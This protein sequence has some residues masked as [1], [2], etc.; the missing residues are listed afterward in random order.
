MRSAGLSFGN[1]SAMQ[2][3]S[4]QSESR[5]NRTSSDGSVLPSGP[6]NNL[7]FSSDMAEAIALYDM[8]QRELAD[9]HQ[10]SSKTS[11]HA[12]DKSSSSQEIIDRH[13]ASHYRPWSS[14]SEIDSR[15]QE[16]PQNC[17]S[18][19]SLLK[20]LDFDLILLPSNTREISL[21]DS[22]STLTK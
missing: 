3:S 1:L 20:N 16:Y 11:D 12:P 7:R 14:D 10:S 18:E 15:V 4:T 5:Q 19:T 2:H 9:S 8:L 17:Q 13:S 6:P 22:I 21:G